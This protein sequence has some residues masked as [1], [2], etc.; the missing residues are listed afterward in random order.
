MG[1]RD[2]PWLDDDEQTA[3]RSYLAMH[4][5]LMLRL[6][7]G[8]QARSD[9]SLGDFAVLVELSESENATMRPTELSRRLRWEQSRLSH[10]LRRMER[11]D[12]VRRTECDEDG[13]GAVVELTATGRRTIEEA[14][15][16]HAGELRSVLV[17][18]L[19]AN[20]MR[21]LGQISESVLAALRTT[22]GTTTGAE[23]TSD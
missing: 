6:E 11:R 9:L 2:G 16:G 8:L 12:L 13:R 15:P 5:D 20:G 3:W 14:A 4:D 18:V 17:D 19:G 23:P 22:T 10:R 21:T 7:R 1:R